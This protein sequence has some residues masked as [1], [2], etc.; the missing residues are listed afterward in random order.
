MSYGAKA[1][2]RALWE[3]R[4]YSD[5]RLVCKGDLAFIVGRLTGIDGGQLGLTH[6]I[7]PAGGAVPV[8]RK[9]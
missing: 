7:V 4:S 3:L 9:S 1:Q 2:A 5:N 6:F 8:G